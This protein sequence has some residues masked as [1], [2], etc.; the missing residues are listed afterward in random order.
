MAVEPGY[1]RMGLLGGPVDLAGLPLPIGRELF[2]DGHDAPQVLA[3]HQG[4]LLAFFESLCRILI[5]RQRDRDSPGQAAAQPHVIDDTVIVIFGHKTGER[6]K[7]A[8]RD[9]FQ[10]RSSHARKLDLG[11]GLCSLQGSFTERAPQDTVH[12]LAAMGRDA[13]NNSSHYFSPT[14][15]SQVLS[16]AITKA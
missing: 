3:V 10:V 13:A 14:Y 8:H 15:L 7:G 4:N 16:L 9:H 12:K 6:T 5:H 2:C 11:K 1:T